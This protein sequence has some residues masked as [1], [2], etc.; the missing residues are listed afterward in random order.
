MTL[1]LDREPPEVV[2]GVE[3]AEITIEMDREQA[4]R[5]AAGELVLPNLILRDEVAW[6]GPVRKYLSLDPVLRGLLARSKAD[7]S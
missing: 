5:F 3:P 7:R 2:A 1:L 6:R 4:A